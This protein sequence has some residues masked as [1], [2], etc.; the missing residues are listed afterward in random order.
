[1]AFNTAVGVPEITQFEVLTDAQA[2]SAVV[3]GLIPQKLKAAPPLLNV[4]GVTDI[5][6]F[7]P[8]VFPV[9]LAYDRLGTEPLTVNVTVAS[10]DAPI[11]FVA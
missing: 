6:E 7:T 10:E 1:M 2:G 3:E 11:E 9:E 4:E 5:G 8:P